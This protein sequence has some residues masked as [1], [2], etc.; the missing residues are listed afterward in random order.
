MAFVRARDCAHAPRTA[1]ATPAP[2]SF[3]AVVGELECATPKSHRDTAGWDY[4][5]ENLKSIVSK[6]FEQATPTHR[7]SLTAFI[8]AIDVK[9]QEYQATMGGGEEWKLA[10]E[11]SLKR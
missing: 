3:V 8:E 7:A 6:G 2:G 1:D 9:T 10:R 11:Q 5:F 4:L